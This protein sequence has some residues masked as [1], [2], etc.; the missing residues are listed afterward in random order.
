MLQGSLSIIKPST[1]EVSYLQ[2]KKKEE[3]GPNE[4]D[5][6]LKISS[7]GSSISISRISS[8]LEKTLNNG[9]ELILDEDEEKREENTS[10]DDQARRKN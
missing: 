2:M 4:K 6:S 8:S 3:D 1:V 10:I 9:A 5:I 7:L